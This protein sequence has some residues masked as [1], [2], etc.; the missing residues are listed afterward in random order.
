MTRDIRE[1]CLRTMVEFLATAGSI[2]TAAVLLLSVVYGCRRLVRSG[3]LR[4]RLAAVL[5]AIAAGSLPW[6]SAVFGQAWDLPAAV[7]F[8]LL[9]FVIFSIGLVGPFHGIQ[10]QVT[11]PVD[12]H[13]GD[14]RRAVLGAT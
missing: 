11:F 12:A 8:S 3:R 4:P 1:R 9:M 2:G 7:G 10:P 6:I 13:H 5:V 14:R